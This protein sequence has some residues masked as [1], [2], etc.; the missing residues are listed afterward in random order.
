[1]SER[2]V[3]VREVIYDQIKT[4]AKQHKKILVPLTDKV[5]VA[6]LSVSIRSASPFSSP[7]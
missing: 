7:I 6:G 4:V 2:H 3:N 1:M 5:H